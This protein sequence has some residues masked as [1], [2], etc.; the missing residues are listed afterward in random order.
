MFWW[1]PLAITWNILEIYIYIYICI[2]V[3]IYIYIYIYV[4]MPSVVSKHII[5]FVDYCMKEKNAF[6][7][8]KL[9]YEWQAF[10][11]NRT[12]FSKTSSPLISVS[13]SCVCTYTYVCVCLRTFLHR[14][15]P[16]ISRLDVRKYALIH[17]SLCEVVCQHVCIYAYVP[18]YASGS[19][20]RVWPQHSL[21]LS[22]IFTYIYMYVCMYMYIYIYIYIYIYMYVCIFLRLKHTSYDSSTGACV[23]TFVSACQ[24]SQF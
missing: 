3:Y 15:S 1:C 20:G 7:M 21:C 13:D 9:I 19:D 16:K 8:L 12:S 6:Q 14:Q 11:S 5:S 18:L 24:I 2:Y 23:R 10:E 22:Y 4:Y 17:Q